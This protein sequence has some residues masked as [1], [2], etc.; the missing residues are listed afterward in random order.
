MQQLSSSQVSKKRFPRFPRFVV[1][2][3]KPAIAVGLGR[4]AI[5]QQQRFDDYSLDNCATVLGGENGSSSFLVI[6]VTPF[7]EKR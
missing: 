3:A 7:R 4:R 6:S 5:A 2:L 1:V